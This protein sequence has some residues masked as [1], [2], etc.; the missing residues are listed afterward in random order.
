M[1]FR[2]QSSAKLLMSDDSITFEE[3]I[4]YKMSTRVEMADRILD[5]LIQAVRSFGD[6]RAQESADVLQAWDRKV[7]AES[8]GAVL[9]NMWVNEMGDSLF[10]IPWSPEDPLNTP[11]GLADPIAAVKTLE[12]AARKVKKKYDALD[13][14]WG[15][16]FRLRYAGADLP[17]SGGYGRLGVFS[18]MTF[19]PDKDDVFKPVHGEGYVAL[20]EFGDPV[21]AKVMMTYGNSTQPGSSHYGDQLD[22]F[23]KREFRTAWRTRQ[24]IEA[25]TEYIDSF[26][27]RPIEH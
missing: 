14:S 21:R 9:F 5:D 25:N 15:E 17:A 18:V 10:A 26:P 16:V 7:D 2:A 6:E 19:F 22:L 1:H 4:Q 13:V 27:T 24:E 23:L 8:R 11:D 20:I 12:S 3:F